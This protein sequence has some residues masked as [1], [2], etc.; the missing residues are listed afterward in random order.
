MPGDAGI[1]VVLVK[2]S[3]SECIR[4]KSIEGGRINDSLCQQKVLLF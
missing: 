2:E 3:Y 1:C 4:M